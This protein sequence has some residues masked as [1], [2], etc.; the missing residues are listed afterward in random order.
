M[1]EDNRKNSGAQDLRNY[2]IQMP[3]KLEDIYQVIS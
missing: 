3:L 2:T 1:Y